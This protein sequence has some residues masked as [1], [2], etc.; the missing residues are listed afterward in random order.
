MMENDQSYFMKRAA[1]ERSAADKAGNPKV[2]EAHEQMAD[3]Y[4]DLMQSAQKKEQP[5]G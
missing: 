4:Q 2:R 1:E 3:R 5:S